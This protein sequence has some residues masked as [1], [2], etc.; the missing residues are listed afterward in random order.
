MHNEGINNK[1]L[2][3]VKSRHLDFCFKARFI[4]LNLL[5][6]FN[7][8]METSDVISQIKNDYCDA[9]SGELTQLSHGT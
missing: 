6:H 7:V 8:F 5:S 3:N 1:C 2:S 4:F 9:V